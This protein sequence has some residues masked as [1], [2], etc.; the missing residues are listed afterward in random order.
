MNDRDPGAHR[1]DPNAQRPG[2]TPDDRRVPDLD[3]SHVSDR[4]EHPRRSADEGR[5]AELTR[6]RLLCQE[7]RCKEAE[8]DDLSHEP[9]SNEW[10]ERDL[11][12]GA[13]SRYRRAPHISHLTSRA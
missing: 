4:I 6:T 8:R 11:H 2:F 3:A 9:T 7:W 13:P 10:D 1:T 12:T 5:D